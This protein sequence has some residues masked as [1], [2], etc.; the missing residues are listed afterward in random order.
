[1]S[2]QGKRPSVNRQ[3]AE[4]E[5]KEEDEAADVTKTKVNETKMKRK[6]RVRGR[7]KTDTSR[8]NDRRKKWYKCVNK[9]KEIINKKNI[10]KELKRSQNSKIISKRQR[11]LTKHNEWFGDKI[12]ENNK[13]PLPSKEG[14]LRIYGQNVNGISKS[15]DYGEWEVVLESLDERQVDIACLTEINIDVN[16]PEV[17]IP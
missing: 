11:N 1:M 13:W 3:M 14:T 6:T 9:W 15:M 5:M 10:I 7:R 17:N 8:D 4:V 16:K 2:C 12:R